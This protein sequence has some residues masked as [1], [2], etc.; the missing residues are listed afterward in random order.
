MNRLVAISCC[1]AL[2]TVAAETGTACADAQVP[3]RTAV[4]R[5]ITNSPKV[6]TA[7]EDVQKAQAA[8]RVAKDIYIPSVVIGGGAG[9]A[10]GITITVPTVFILSAQSLVYSPQQTSYVRAALLDLKAANLALADAR[11]QAAEDAADTYLTIIHDQEAVEAISQQFGYRLKLVSIIEDRVAAHMDSEID[12]KKARRDALQARLAVMQIEDF[13]NTQRSRLAALTG[14]DASNLVALAETVPDLPEVPE[15]SGG[16]HEGPGMLAA[17]ASEASRELRAR[18]DKQYVWRPNVSFGAQ[19]ARISPIEGVAQYYNLQGNYNAA[20]FGIQINLPLLDRVRSA[21]ARV[22]AADS[23]HSAIDL[24]TQKLEQ[25]GQQGKLAR[26]AAELK[27][28][29]QL[30]DLD[31]GIA[32]DQLQSLLIAMHASSGGPPVTPKEEQ[33]ARIEERQSY[34]ETID[35]RLDA[36]RAEIAYL[37]QSGQLDDWIYLPD[38]SP[39]LPR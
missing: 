18:A 34:I 11:D 28:K 38:S 15:T 5:S 12:L 4:E 26:D 1:L 13:L 33:N 7:Q 37:R 32:Q 10:S 3:F 21:A 6:R 22:S 14:I 39:S 27:L 2:F 35:A 19:Y 24:E 8:V 9:D 25:A 23:A 31:Y 17:E 16:F 29:A 36:S 20:S 30:A